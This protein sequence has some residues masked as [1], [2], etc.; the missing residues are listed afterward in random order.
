MGHQSVCRPQGRRDGPPLT[1]L[2]QDARARPLA[3]REGGGAFEARPGPSGLGLDLGVAEEQRSADD[4]KAE[5]D[6][7]A[8]IIAAE[9]ELEADRPAAG[10]ALHG[11]VAAEHGAAESLR[12][13][14]ERRRHATLGG[15]RGDDPPLR[16]I[17]EETQR[18]V[19]S[20]FA[21][22]IGARDDVER[23]ELNPHVAQ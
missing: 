22:A 2:G 8:V 18:P 5:I 21:G 17:G 13:G 12:S 23:P 4:R 10:L 11:L 6:R 20:R 1:G 19:E 7:V 9:A 14:P 15:E 3:P 16:G